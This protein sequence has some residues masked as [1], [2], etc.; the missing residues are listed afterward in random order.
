MFLERRIQEK[1]VG[2]REG[3]RGGERKGTDEFDRL[4]FPHC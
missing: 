4:V 1:G 2:G 3:R